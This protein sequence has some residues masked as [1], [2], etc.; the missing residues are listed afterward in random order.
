MRAELLPSMIKTDLG[1][2]GLD[3]SMLLV[4]SDQEPAIKELQEEI[5]R[6]RRQEDAVGTILENSKVGDSSNNGTT[7][8][9]IQEVG[10]MI[11]TPKFALE[12]NRWGQDVA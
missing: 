6:Q 8:R 1:T 11:R 12:A 4:K 10:G 7:E 2:C 5:A 3:N 9:A